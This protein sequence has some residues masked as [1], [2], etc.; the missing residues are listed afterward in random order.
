MR[1][2]PTSLRR[3][4]NH[5][6]ADHVHVADLVASATVRIP[7]T[8]RSP[9]RAII[10]RILLALAAL[11]TAAIVVYLGRSGYR[12]SSGTELSFVDAFYYA[13]TS[14]STTGYGDIAPLSPKARL[15]NILVITPLRVI[16][17]VLLV[18]TT[19]AALTETSRQVA[20]IRRWRRSTAG[21]TVLVGYGTKGRAAADAV[22]AD[23]PDAEVAV[24]DTDRSAQDAA[25]AR[26]L[27]TVAGSGAQRD[28]LSAA[29][30][31]RA[32]SI[33]IAVDRDDTC[34]LVTL[35]ARQL[36]PSAYIV[37]AVRRTESAHLVRQCGADTVVV[38]QE[39]V[40]RLL[41]VAKT[42]PTVVDAFED[43]LS[44]DHGLSITERP[45]SEHEHGR[46]PLDCGEHILGVVR[47]G[48][49][50]DART[51]AEQRLLPGDRLLYLRGE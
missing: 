47:S 38:S 51:T 2:P 45:L 40:G 27:T 10:R 30:V 24:V 32:K 4:A 11:F 49:L 41:G 44:P 28:I 19:L 20:R 5:V 42:S 35:T 13:T 34:V 31:S 17:L 25:A 37:A 39:M 21:H 23:N 26:A 33:I 6:R 14:L 43:L 16:F 15:T 12:H 3:R 7:D 22:F 18:G 48:T 50:L 1:N 8:A 9:R 46:S 29:A 36:A